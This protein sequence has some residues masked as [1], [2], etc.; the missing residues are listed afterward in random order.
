MI[1]K[2]A[3]KAKPKNYPGGLH[4]SPGRLRSLEERI[5]QIES[6]ENRPTPNA[7]THTLVVLRPD[8]GVDVFGEPHN[9][10][11]VINLPVASTIENERDV[12]RLIESVLPVPYRK[13]YFAG[14]HLRAMGN[15]R[16]VTLADIIRV[17]ENLEAIGSTR[18]ASP[19]RAQLAALEA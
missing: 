10:V 11:K 18:Y 1:A 19:K 6:Q 12:E 16:I 7:K 5:K 14:Q 13:I 8:G 9:Q 4:K 3:P 15:H 2:P 17:T